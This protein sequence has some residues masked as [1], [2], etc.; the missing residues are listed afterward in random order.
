MIFSRVLLPIARQYKPQLI[1][2]SA[3]FDIAQG[4]PLG[5]MNVTAEGFACLARLLQELSDE[6]CPGRLAI[7]LEGGYDLPSIAHG[8]SAVLETLIVDAPP[9]DATGTGDGAAS[10]ETERVVASV[11][12]TQG[13]FWRVSR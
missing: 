1:L 7:V 12:E 13:A 10:P 6:C 8:V 11:L 5:G 2:V 4:D 9:P 3:G